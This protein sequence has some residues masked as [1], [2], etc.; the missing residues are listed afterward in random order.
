M[1]LGPAAPDDPSIGMGAPMRGQCHCGTRVRVCFV[2]VV[3][4]FGVVCMETGRKR[5]KKEEETLA[6]RAKYCDVYGSALL[7]LL[8][9]SS[10]SL[11]M[12]ETRT[13]LGAVV[14][15]TRLCEGAVEGA[16]RC[17]CSICSK[18]GI[19]MVFAPVA[20]D[21]VRVTMG[22]EKLTLYTFGSCT[23]K[24]WFCS[25]CG[26]YMYH[27]TRA[28]QDLYAVNAAVI[29]GIDADGMLERSIPVFDGK[30]HPSDRISKTSS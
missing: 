14:I 15:E 1:A 21:G 17:S 4:D 11:V 27:Q 9:F 10:S 5:R 3:R 30:N 12:F 20:N 25:I 24:H 22:C 7:C 2:H 6:K 28:R 18:K 16:H 29:E 19:I 26:V 8:L 23:A 13:Q